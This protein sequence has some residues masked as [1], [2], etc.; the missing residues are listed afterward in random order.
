MPGKAL[1][2]GPMV[3]AR[4][5]LRLKCGGVGWPPTGLK[6]ECAA[7]RGWYRRYRRGVIAFRDFRNAS[8]SGAIMFPV[9]SLHVCENSADPRLGVPRGRHVVR[10]GPAEVYWPNRRT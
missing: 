1:S 8:A 2:C 5:P 3:A 10:E 9:C 6:G 4:R 7:G